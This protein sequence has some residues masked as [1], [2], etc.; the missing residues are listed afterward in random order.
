MQD[1]EWLV[2]TG[3]GKCRAGATVGCLPFAP[4]CRTPGA[5]PEHAH[6]L[7]A[8]TFLI[9]PAHH[10]TGGASCYSVADAAA[11]SKASNCATYKQHSDIRLCSSLAHWHRH[12]QGY[13]YGLRTGA[14]SGAHHAS[15]SALWCHRDCVAAVLV[16]LS[17][18]AA[19][20]SYR[21]AWAH[22]ARAFGTPRSPR[23]QD[24]ELSQGT[25]RLPRRICAE[26]EARA[27]KYSLHW[28]RSIA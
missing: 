10:T 12:W 28:G 9:I 27:P 24:P 4:V 19:A 18:H 20:A 14:A 7:A 11:S 6:V 22:Q 2:G 16:H 17:L 25:G 23:G 21:R 8:H 5:A 1:T 13:A 15:V 3:T 26:L